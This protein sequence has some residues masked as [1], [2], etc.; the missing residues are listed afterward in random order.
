MEANDLQ[1]ALDLVLLFEPALVRSEEVPPRNDADHPS[2]IFAGHQEVVL[3][4]HREP[5]VMGVRHGRSLRVA[6]SEPRGTMPGNARMRMAAI[7]EGKAIREPT[8]PADPAPKPVSPRAE[9]QAWAWS[10]LLTA[11]VLAIYALHFLSFNF[12][13]PTG[14]LVLD[15]PYYMANAREHFD[16]GTFHW[17]Y[18]LPFSPFADTPRIYV[19]PISLALGTLHHLTGI[20]PGYLFV[21]WGTVA[22]VACVRVALALLSQATNKPWHDQRLL[23]VLFL[24]GGGALTIASWARLPARGVALRDAPDI[25]PVLFSLD[26]FAGYWFLNLGRN[27]Y[28]S[29]EAHYHLLSLGSLLLLWRRRYVPGLLVLALL[30]A[31]H[32]F[33]GTQIALIACVWLLY[34]WGRST[35]ATAQEPAGASLAVVLGALGILGVHLWYYLAFL[36]TSPEHRTLQRAWVEGTK[37]WVLPAASAVLAYAP[38]AVVVWWRL[39]SAA[40]FREAIH[41]P[42]TRLLLAWLLVC[43]GLENHELFM[44]GHQPLHFTRGYTWTALFLLAAPQLE[45]WLVRPACTAWLRQVALAAMVTFLLSDNAGWFGA[46]FVKSLIFRQPIGVYLSPERKEVLNFLAS[47]EYRDCLLLSADGYLGYFST[48]YTPLRAWASHWWN[49]PLYRDRVQQLKEFFEQGR[50]QSEW[51]QRRLIVVLLDAVAGKWQETSVAASFRP[52]FRVGQYTVLVQR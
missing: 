34:E 35:Q 17:L 27:L 7:L 24:W 4:H 29:T 49:T 6:R 20:D 11:P 5:P 3:V 14:F 33:S 18:G 43:L 39:R 40:R 9:W 30:C 50:M 15:M 1:T 45:T 41:L 32:P 12:G 52:V 25:M 28:Y 26:P 46:Q 47:D 42:Q 51:R 19:Q 13:I 48:V 16:D 37:D 44:Q 22:A 21:A 2:R 23:T 8:T 10:L 31:S 38:I 36:N